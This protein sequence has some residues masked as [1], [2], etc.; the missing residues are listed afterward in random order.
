MAYF[1]FTFWAFDQAEAIVEP[2]PGL[3]VAG[4]LVPWAW[5]G[6]ESDS[7]VGITISNLGEEEITLDPGFCI[8]SLTS[9]GD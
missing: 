3:G 2:D 9:V 1:D 4:L 6:F 5:V 7:I 8:S